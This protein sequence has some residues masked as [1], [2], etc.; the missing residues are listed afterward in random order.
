[1]S[2]RCGYEFDIEA[3]EEEHDRP[4]EIN[5]SEEIVKYGRW[6]CPHEVVAGHE[7]CIFHLAPEDRPAD[8]DP[9]SRFVEA[10]EGDAP[11]QFIGAVFPE[12][13]L[14]G[15]E[16]DAEQEVDIR[17]VRVGTLSWNDAT[18]RVDI[19][20]SGA[21]FGGYDDR[22]A[23]S[24]FDSAI[25]ARLMFKNAIFREGVTF[26]KAEF[27]G[28]IFF[29]ECDLGPEAD[30]FRAKFR[31]SAD[32]FGATFG[33]SASFT[34]AQF[35][36]D[37][38]FSESDFD[39]NS[40]FVGTKFKSDSFFSKTKFGADVTFLE[41]EF[42]SDTTF[43]NAK[44][45]DNP[46][47]S[48]IK[49]RGKAEFKRAKFGDSTSF[50]AIEF[51]SEISF[52]EVNF[53]VDV[54]FSNTNLKQANF[55]DADL[56]NANFEDADLTRAALYGADLTNAKLYGARLTDA[57]ISDATDFGIRGRGTLLPEF[58]PGVS[59]TPEVAYDP[60]TEPTPDD[61]DDVNNY[62]KAAAVYSDLESLAEDNA[63]S[64]LA[65]KCFAWRK[66]MQRKRYYS[67][68]GDG[69]DRDLLAGLWASLSNGLMRYGESP[70]RLL[71]WAGL[72]VTVCGLLYYALDLLVPTP[73]GTTDA[74]VSLLDAL[75]FS[76]LT[77]TT[78]GMGDYRPANELGRALAIFETS[79]GVILL[80]L[81]VFV[82]GRRATR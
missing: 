74:T 12:F 63:A 42:Q 49:F 26:Q 54:S 8:A 3:W 69:N 38:F 40:Y 17:H 5:L 29:L 71:G 47:L 33:P 52:F 39:E 60:R 19:D 68:D 44:F 6:S 1:M 28:D 48:E 7:E 61:Y 34:E 16:L 82:F 73:Q 56:S 20:A 55:R 81:L 64:K 62:T 57:R 22:R 53:D 24:N 11:N 10:I 36:S 31:E 37:T 15:Q 50:K 75:Y 2:D 66:D 78:L 18:V 35:N 65:R 9:V 43:Q 76:T 25:F 58:F 32:F 72:L 70:Y 80:A 51:G 27:K 21:V 23:E 4:C 77:F 30:F 46:T 67:A 79:A 13:D 41:T 45:R 14:S 59:P